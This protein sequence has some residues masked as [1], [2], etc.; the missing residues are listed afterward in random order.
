MKTIK[1]ANK[2][3]VFIEVPDDAYDFKIWGNNVLSYLE[4][5][6]DTNF[7][8]TSFKNT[9]ILNTLLKINN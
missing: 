6:T 4:K 2:E 5:S 3:Y 1:I 9:K 8:I 7:N